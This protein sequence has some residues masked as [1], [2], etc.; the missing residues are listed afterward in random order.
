MQRMNIMKQRNCFQN[1]GYTMKNLIYIVLFVI[2]CNSLYALQRKE[3]L[4]IINNA[5]SFKKK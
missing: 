5:E 4:K 1:K 3:A 2:V